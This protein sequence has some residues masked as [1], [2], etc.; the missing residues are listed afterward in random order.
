LVDTIVERS[1]RHGAV[2]V[3]PGVVNIS[4]AIVYDAHQG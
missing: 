1:P 3:S 4:S 2:A